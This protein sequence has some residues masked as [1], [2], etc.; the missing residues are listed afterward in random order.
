MNVVREDLKDGVALLK[1]QVES[2][3]YTDKVN[4]AIEKY[5]KNAKIPGFRPGKIPV[6]LIKKQYGKGLLAEEL[7]RLVSDTLFKYINDNKLE[8]IGQPIPS[9]THEVK[10]DFE[11]PTDF[12]FFYDIAITPEFEIPLTKSTKLT[13]NK[14]DVD[15]DLI[16]KQVDDLRRRYGKLVSSEKV[17]EK[18][19]ILAQFTELNDD[20]TE[21]EG[22]ISN[23]STISME[24]VEDKATKKALLDKKIGDTVVVN[25]RSVSKGESDMAA[26]LGVKGQDLT[27]IGE[28]YSMKINEIKHIELA[29]M[30]QELFDK[31]FGEA[32]V[33]S[34]AELK[35]KVQK[36]L[37]DMFANDSDR[38]VMRDAYNHLLEN[39]KIALP[40]DFLKR[41]ISLSSEK[42]MDA[43]EL[44]NLY[45]EYEKSLRWQIIQGKIFKENNLQLKQEEVIGFAKDLILK[46]YAQYGIP[47][48]EDKDLTAS[49]NQLLTNK[50]E[51]NRI[52]DMIAETKL[53]EFVKATAKLA[54]TKVS[55]DKFVE[56]ANAQ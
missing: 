33:K 21:K 42:P 30:N 27:E 7:N 23:N 20:E 26:M 12:E 46:Q 39:T 56:I 25:P 10:G 11:N 18:D 54:D 45:P 48:P 2:A 29:E 43:A 22:G 14:V 50:E 1:I 8:I 40:E 13:Y 36:D 17:G 37:E 53:I 49:A 47:A 32:K 4:T 41:W 31:L 16:G 44:E 51:S 38:L 24:F 15:N 55:Y 52:Y 9:S 6:G 19:M 28:K 34:E 3:D 35:A 5:R